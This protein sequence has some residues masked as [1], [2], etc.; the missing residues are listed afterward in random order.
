MMIA[1]IEISE[2]NGEN[3]SKVLHWEYRD[4]LCL[5]WIYKIGRLIDLACRGA[6]PMS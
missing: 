3:I 1:C 6:N 4:C 2:L 5:R